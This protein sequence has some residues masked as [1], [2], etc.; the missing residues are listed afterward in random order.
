MDDPVL[1]PEESPGAWGRTL[2]EYVPPGPVDLDH[3]TPGIWG[4]KLRD[5]VPPEP[6]DIDAD[7]LD[8]RQQGQS[9]DDLF[10]L[11]SSLED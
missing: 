10:I 9:K 2:R 5:Y 3:D 8:S 1:H 11:T 7:T 6:V 4:K